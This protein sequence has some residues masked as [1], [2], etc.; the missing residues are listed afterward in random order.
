MKRELE[1][2]YIGTSYGG[3][4]DWFR[5]FMMRVGGCAAETACGS[6]LYFALRF[7]LKKLYPFD[8][9]HLTRKEYVDFAHRMEPY[10]KPRNHGIDR[11][12]IFT[13]GY[14]KYLTEVGE[15]RLTMREFSGEKKHDDAAEA[16]KSQIDSGFP[17]PCLTLRHEDRRYR[18][19]VWHWYLLNGYETR[20]YGEG[21]KR[22]GEETLMVKAVTYSGYEWLDLREL[23]DTGND[24]KGGLILFDVLG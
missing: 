21:A 24:P 16:V 15:S 6:S 19:Y 5:S 23:W 9:E 8:A 3:N 4:Q 2:F 10:L 7:G 11:L 12:S 13:D 14:A 18:D 22:C 1:H 20:R 17:I